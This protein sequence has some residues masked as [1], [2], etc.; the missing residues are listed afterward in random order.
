VPGRLRIWLWRYLPAEAVSLF[1]AVLSGSVAALLTDNNA[2]AAA[3]AGAW[4]ETTAY[5]ATML[6]RE[7]RAYPQQALWRTLANLTM[8]FG[9]A[10]ALDAMLVRPTLMYLA[11]QALSDIRLGI[12]VG[13]VAADAV[14]YIPTITA[15][16]LRRHYF[17]RR[18][19]LRRTDSLD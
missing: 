11:G 7:R 15:Y 3:L 18:G 12:L 13:K 6:L 19:G 2:A 5:Y 17:E 14:F 9:V 1:A 10:E 16:E 8:E 4:G